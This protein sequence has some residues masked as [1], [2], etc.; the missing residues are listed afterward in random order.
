MTIIRWVFVTI[1]HPKNGEVVHLHLKQPE[2]IS[3]TEWWRESPRKVMKA[4]NEAVKLFKSIMSG[5]DAYNARI[6]EDRLFKA[7]EPIPDNAKIICWFDLKIDF[8]GKD[9]VYRTGDFQRIVFDKK[10]NSVWDCLVEVRQHLK[11]ELAK[12]KRGKK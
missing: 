6:D 2:Q 4:A 3:S 8:D 7:D 5:N 12:R 9:I 1:P 10:Y 11:E